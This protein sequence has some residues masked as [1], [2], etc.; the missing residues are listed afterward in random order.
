[1]FEIEEA[2]GVPL[3]DVSE[4]SQ[5]VAAVD[6]GIARMRSGFPLSNRLLREVHGVLLAQGRGSG[7]D[8]GNFRRSQNWIGGPRRS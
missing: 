1:M 4:V 2:P 7:K 6:H 5:Y 8:P 3:A